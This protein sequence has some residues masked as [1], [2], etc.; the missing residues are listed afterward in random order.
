ADAQFPDGG[1]EFVLRVAAPQRILGLESGDRVYSMR[2][3]EGRRRRLAQAEVTHLPL[4]HQLRHGADGLF[5]GDF[6]I[7][8]VLVVEVDVI[9]PHPLSRALAGL[10]PVP[11]PA[12]YAPASPTVRAAHEAELRGHPHC[13][14]PAADR[15]ADQFLVG[16][17][18]VGV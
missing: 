3:A 7:D 15:L 6:G 4:P 17:R 9:A 2:P 11:R 18:A 5:N 8:T 14:T 10:A 1:E 13:V 12:A 16:E